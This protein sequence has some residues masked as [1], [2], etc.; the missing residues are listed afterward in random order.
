[1]SIL[2]VL[3]LI[4]LHLVQSSNSKKKKGA[5]DLS[6]AL[7]VNKSVCRLCGTLVILVNDICI[8]LLG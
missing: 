2:G 8:H 1:M 6:H 7:G 5:R 3:V 4:H